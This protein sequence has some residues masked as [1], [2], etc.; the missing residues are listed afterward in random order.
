MALRNINEWD[1]IIG[2]VC[3]DKHERNKSR[4]YFDRI[5]ATDSA[6][7]GDNWHPNVLRLIASLVSEG[8]TDEEILTLAE[9]FTLLGYTVEQT[10]QEFQKMIDGA[11]L[12]GFAK[13]GEI[14]RESA[15]LFSNNQI[16][17]SKFIRSEPVEI[18]LTNFV[19]EIISEAAIT[20]GVDVTKTFVVEGTL[21]TGQPLPTVA[22]EAKAF[23]KLEWL[24]TNWGASA[25]VTVGTKHKEHVTAA[26]K[27]KSNPTE[28]TVYS[29][30]GWI[31]KTGKFYYLS[32][33]GGIYTAGL[34]QEI[35]TELQGSLANYDL[36]PP[37]ESYNQKLSDI[38]QN[39]S[40]LID[41]GTALLL[42]GAA[43]RSTLSYFTKSTVSVFLQ[44]T[45]GTYKT[46]TAGCIQAFFG[47]NFNGTH[48]PE[49]WSSTGN[50][51]EKKA[52]LCKDALFSIDDFV[53]RGTPSE[54]SRLHRDAERVLRAQGNQSGRDRLTSTTALRGAYI[55]RGMILA[56]G[57][58]VPNGHSLQARCVIL[59]V[60]KG[61]TD[62]NILTVLQKLAEEEVLAQL[63]SNFLSWVAGKAD[64]KQVNDLMKIAHSDC[65]IK[66]PTSGHTR[67]RDNLASLMSGF[68]LLLQFGKELCDFSEGEITRLKSATLNA[69][70][71]VAEL[72]ITADREASDTDRFIELLRSS[73]A[74]GAAHLATKKG[75]CPYPLASAWGWKITGTR[76]SEIPYGQGT[77]IGWI[78]GNE[79]LLDMTAT[80]SVLRPLS[81]RLG[82]HLGSS[83]RAINKALFEAGML[84]KYDEGRHKTKVSVEGR[85]VPVISLPVSCIMDL[86]DDEAL[87]E[88]YAP[89]KHEAPF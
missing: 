43:C 83:E 47:K 78:D 82:N 41:D 35:E 54:V 57:E 5:A 2:R 77:K 22:V 70:K 17:L 20:D 1:H 15:Y 53:A 29:H 52:F 18:R 42:V 71:K 85:R 46:A 10:R 7:K 89:Q 28:R 59:S 84:A 51:L 24:P 37:N 27:E 62:I 25:Q 69:A 74:M 75:F 4:A 45:T 3:A 64:A 30:T 39:F 14:F 65:M 55:P 49:N 48:L 26:I 8:K 72:Q 38:L 16:Y 58:D 34:N 50:A 21:H 56:T 40:N 73:L 44:G 87:S 80:L 79:I 13:S 12:K 76:G 9:Y 60:R 6:L 68:W 66:L 19:A 67:M 23:D 81:T 88:D 86:E 31:D 11:R 61:A 63:M 36:P 33:R 32:N